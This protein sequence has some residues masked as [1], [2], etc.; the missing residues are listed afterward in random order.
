MNATPGRVRGSERLLIVNADD[1]GLSEDID[2]G[3]LRAFDAGIV[4]SAS[5]V[6]GGSSFASA[7]AAARARPGLDL[8]AHLTLVGERPVLD[9]A[10]VPSLVA[11]DGRFPPDAAAFAARYLAGRVRKEELRQELAA[12]L[13][14]IREAGL[15]VSHLDSHQHLH[16]L[17]GLAPLV[18]DLAL[19]AGIRY[20]RLP[21]EV[22]PLWRFDR[23]PSPGRLHPAAPW[24][25]R[26][27]A[28]VL[29]ACAT[30]AGGAWRRRGL[31][32]PT[33]FLGFLAGG[34]LDSAALLTLLDHVG[35]G[36]TELM[37][38]PGLGEAA[39]PHHAAW[40]YRWR[41]ELA[42]LTDPQA[43]R[44]LAERR[45]RLLGFGELG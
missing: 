45:I 25:R 17:P 1:F 8:G 21:R 31:E 36:V 44:R 11:P 12:Q 2:G 42:A 19:S 18:G 38:H 28:A 15:K 22:A 33:T 40:G 13:A 5:L 32:H 23:V 7:A 37:C 14:R 26:L 9:P 29:G 16:V 24:S 35:E 3:I 20:L 34:R 43:Q 30:L 27:Q 4:T 6:A 41:D 10:Q 39:R